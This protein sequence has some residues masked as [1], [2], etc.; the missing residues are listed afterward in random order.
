MD[1]KITPLNYKQQ[2][3]LLKSY[4]HSYYVLD[5]P[6]VTDDEY[7]LLYHKIKAFE[8]SNPQ[9][10]DTTSP[11]QRVGETPLDSF[12]KSTH[13]E[14]M[15]SLDDVFSIEELSEWVKRIYKSYPDATFTCSPKFDGA[16]LNLLYKDGFLQ[17]AATRGNGLIGELVS[18]N[19]KTIKTIPLDI[20]FKGTIEI[21]GEV[22]IEKQD[23]ESINL[24]R[25]KANQSL[26]AN[27]RNAAAGSL[28][29]LD[30]KITASRKLK[31]M[32][33]GIGFG[34]ENLMSFLEKQNKSCGFHQA[35]NAIFSFG[36]KKVP[37]FTHC[38]NIDEIIE[39]FNALLAKRYEYSIMLDGMVIMVD[40]F[41]IQ[42]ALGWTIKSPRFACA[43]KFPAIE[44]SSRL[45]SIS[46]QV[47]RSGVITPVA[48]LEPL[49][50]DGAMIARATLHNF[51]EIE[52]KDIML[53]DEVIIIRSGD[54]IPKIIKPLIHKRDG[55]QKPIQRPTHCPECGGL[56]LVESIFIKCQNLNC[57]ARML[58]SI[59]HFASKK[60][61][62]IDGLGE[63]I[64]VQLFNENLISS[65]LDLYS[66]NLQDLLKLEG[67]KEKRAQNLLDSISKT[68]GIE[69]WR[70]IN[71]LGIEHIGEGASKKLAQRFGL[72]VFSISLDSVMNL[73]GFGTEMANS[74]IEFNITNKELIAKLLEI[75]KPIVNATN[76]D[77]SN[78][79]FGKSVVIT[80]TLSKPREHFVALLESMGAHISSSV[81]KKTDFVLC[82]ENAGSKLDKAKS[83]NIN[84]LTEQELDSMH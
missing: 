56:L 60:A 64:I 41:K 43:F 3:E 70:L 4:A 61:L 7:D 76:I 15:W 57:K 11:T 30:S 68:K 79:F 71:A 24:D 73:D 29:Q 66:L 80:G 65:I 63:K 83:L 26:F 8:S 37:F 38:K 81:S 20:P 5:N 32:P 42:E 25:Q 53:N 19:A 78:V 33:W 21:R 22:V 39:S 49:E 13:L 16:S 6:L 69:L 12:D 27:P 36:F 46:L 40:S 51:S 17:S 48:N 59:T 50:I 44:K 9:L 31:F 62:N 35:M 77:S 47:G 75:I 58:T 52:K 54:V 84:I 2:I 45:K 34:K 18:Q 14:R 82:G 74:L 72:E 10:I 1:I 28:R 67:W 23:F 55:T